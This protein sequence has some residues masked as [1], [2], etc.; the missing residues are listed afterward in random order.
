MNYKSV[1]HMTKNVQRVGLRVLFLV[2]MMVWGTACQDDDPATPP[3]ISGFSPATGGLPGSN[4]T[5]AGNNFSATPAGNAVLFN[6]VTATVTAATS[7]QLTVT[8]PQATTGKITVTV[9]GMTATSANDFII[10]IPAPVITGFSPST[11]R[12][13]TAV[14]ITGSHFSKT[15]TENIVK[16][17]GV[18]AKVTQ[19]SE[20]SLTVTSPDGALTGKITVS[21]NGQEAASSADFEA[22][23]TVYVAGY[24]FDSD[25]SSVQVAEYWKDGVLASLTDATGNSSIS[26]IDVVGQDVYLAGVIGDAKTTYAAYWKNGAVVKL[27]GETTYGDATAID[28]IGNDVHVAGKE[29]NK[30]VYWK[31]GVPTYLT[32]GTTSGQTEGMA[33]S[34]ND[35]YIIGNEGDLGKYW[36]NGVAVELGW[37][38]YPYAITVAG[39]DVHIAYFKDNAVYHW[40]NGESKKIS[41]G[42]KEAIPW[43]IVV[44]G[45]DVHIVGRD[46]DKAAYWKNGTPVPLEEGRDAY[47]L[48]ILG[49][50]VYIAGNDS[51]NRA[52]YWKNGVAINLTEAESGYEA[53]SLAIMVR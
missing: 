17:N 19:A 12:A 32:D 47:A 35:V 29:L 43:D 51:S 40:K 7:T 30:I 46:G 44:S 48:F 14:T 25:N 52:K 18:T 16:F 41:D 50:D 4:A 37:D 36:K 27:T 45:T 39:N 8:V 49:S 28:V 22:V 6:G 5:I 1:K 20:T 53:A 21:V 33:I 31:N 9:N 2:A 11:G 26:A 34:G 13:A 24:S 38:T 15:L 3:A 10:L 42:N 23:H